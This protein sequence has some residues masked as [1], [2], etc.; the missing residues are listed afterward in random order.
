MTGT[1]FSVSTTFYSPDNVNIGGGLLE[2]QQNFTCKNIGSAS[3]TNDLNDIYEGRIDITTS[4]TTGNA[5]TENR[6]VCE[7]E[8]NYLNISIIPG[9]DDSFGNVPGVLKDYKTGQS[10]GNW[11]PTAHSYFYD[12][13]NS[14]CYSILTPYDG[15]E[16]N[17]ASSVEQA[18]TLYIPVNSS[19]GILSYDIG[20]ASGGTGTVTVSYPVCDASAVAYLYLLDYDSEQSTLLD[21]VT[22]SF[23]GGGTVKIDSSDNF[24]GTLNNLKI[25]H[26]YA[27]ALTMGASSSSPSCGGF[28]KIRQ[29]ESMD[30]SIFVYDGDFS[31]G[32]WSECDGTT[33]TRTCEDANGIAP[34]RIEYQTCAVGILDN[35]TLGFE[36]YITETDIAK[37]LPEWLFITQY[38]NTR[39]SRDTPVNWTVVEAENV[40]RDFLRMTQDWASEG[41]RSLMMW[42]IPPKTGEVI[43]NETC[44][45]SS[46]GV[47]GS[48]TQM[49]NNDTF[50][51]NH[52]VQ[53]PAPNMMVSF[54]VKGCA[55]QVEQHGAL[56]IFGLVVVPQLCYASNCSTIP[57][58]YY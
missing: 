58:H 52:D 46:V 47:A 31:C 13:Y 22:K 36:E 38:N 50:S 12:D 16:I 9:N 20:F 56:N 11:Y 25:D 51:V 2:D 43:D 29:P 1:D 30:F 39:V 18:L 6:Y 10:P 55:Q 8:E 4:A 57:D 26:H 23:V 21:S 48:V 24:T 32:E 34:D 44:G 27:L 15:N 53:F 45:N 3:T 42:H 54:D 40:K 41:S 37:C 5:T 35:A 19:S 33:R 14:G 49:N 7:I 28:S 17:L